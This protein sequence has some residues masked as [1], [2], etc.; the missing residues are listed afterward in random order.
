MGENDR[1]PSIVTTNHDHKL[2]APKPN[3]AIEQIDIGKHIKHRNIETNTEKDIEIK[4]KH[5]PLRSKNCG[6][7]YP[8]RDTIS[9]NDTTASHK[10]LCQ[11]NGHDSPSMMAL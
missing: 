8:L 4:E 5:D 3:G 11:S 1:D 9:L 2:T 10:T 6:I 7:V